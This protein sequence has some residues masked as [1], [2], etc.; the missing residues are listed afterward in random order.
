MHTLEN[1]QAFIWKESPLLIL[2]LCLVAAILV[3]PFYEGLERMVM[4]W[5]TREEYSHGFLLPLISL[6]LIYQKK[7]ELMSTEFRGSWLGIPLTVFGLF[8]YVLGELSTLYILVQY[9][10]LIT[11]AGLLLSYAGMQGFRW[12]IV[13]LA[14]LVLMIPLPQFIYQNLSAQLQLISSEIG[15]MV[16]RAFG[17]PVHLQG[18]VIDLGSMKLQVVEACSGLRYLFPLMTIGFIMGY[19]YQGPFLL[20][21]FVFVSSIPITVL[22]NSLRIG[23]IGVTVEYWGQSMAEGILHDFE[24]WIIFMS[25]FFILVGE[26]WLFARLT[27]NKKPLAYVFGVD[28]PDPISNEVERKQRSVPKPLLASFVA[29][30]FIALASTQLASREEIIPERKNFATFPIYVDQWA[31]RFVPM[32]QKYIDTLRF[33]DYITSNYKDTSGNI[34][35]FYTAY[36]DSQRKG[37]SA[38]SPRSC[39]PGGGWKLSEM[40]A[41]TVVDDYLNGEPLTVNRVVMEKDKH[42]SLVYYW[43]Q[44]RG[45]IITNEYLVKWFLF[46]DSL[47]RN[48]TD[49]ALVRLVMDVPHDQDIEAKEEI[50]KQFAYQISSILPD[51]VPN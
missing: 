5:S 37:E 49:G 4:N 3:V 28:M 27:G 17:I 16:I 20:R 12:L 13:P 15:V 32:E 19:F 14:I 48:R 7:N 8:V 31:G 43:F 40:T 44:Q 9:S 22:M 24:G 30:L 45:R 34:I 2:L 42:R 21:V 46:W 10:F 51:Y 41:T 29:V 18:N 23:M 11:L 39:L 6:F 35:N 47:T 25:C 33:E 38:H 50:L 26:I 36:Y 1:R